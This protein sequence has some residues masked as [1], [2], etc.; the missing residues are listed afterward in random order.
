MRNEVAHLRSG[1]SESAARISGV[2]GHAVQVP[3][4]PLCAGMFS[5]GLNSTVG[6]AP[7]GRFAQAPATHYFRFV[8]AQ[9][10]R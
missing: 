10:W 2:F 3:M 8:K 1:T 6:L 9:V 4:C 7:R 5:D